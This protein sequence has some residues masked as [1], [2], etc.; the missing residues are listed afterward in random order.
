MILGCAGPPLVDRATA[1]PAQSEASARRVTV[2]FFPDDTDQCGPAV[3]A[4]VL[5][6]WGI[7]TDPVALKEEIYLPRLKG[8][9][10]LDLLLAAQA[11]GLAAEIYRGSLNDLKAQLAAGHPLV[12]LLDLGFAIFP[13]GHY[14]VVTGYDDQRQG[15]YVHSS[16]DKDVFV[17]YERFLPSWDKT[18]RWTLL[19]TPSERRL[20]SHA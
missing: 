14:V 2:P 17:P 13:Q 10:P 8:T 12:A 1:V 5:T 9:L 7:Q 15:V 11:R 3:L 6:Y 19:V 18:G 20:R 4:S 16:L